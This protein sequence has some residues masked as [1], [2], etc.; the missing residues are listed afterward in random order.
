MELL[1]AR[2]QVD[3]FIPQKFAPDK[4]NEYS[5]LVYSCQKCNRGKWHYWPTQSI[6]QSYNDSEGFVDPAT[7]EFDFHLER[8]DNGEIVGTTEV[9]KY[10]VTKMKLDIR[11]ISIIWKVGVLNK[12]LKTME[13]IIENKPDD[14]SS[15]ELYQ[16]Y[17]EATKQLRHSLNLLYEQNESI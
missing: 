17:M 9:G 2:A 14:P 5:N 15:L 11:P 12:K 3:H 4:E 13:T 8:L 16:G 6:E 10:M 7:D 1:K